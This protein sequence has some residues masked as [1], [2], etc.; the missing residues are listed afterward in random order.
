M[1]CADTNTTL[2][3]KYCKRKRLQLYV[4][5]RGYSWNTALIVLVLYRWCVYLQLRIYGRRKLLIRQYHSRCILQQLK[6]IYKYSSL[7]ILNKTCFHE[8]SHHEWTNRAR[9]YVFINYPQQN[10]SLKL[11]YSTVYGS[12]RGLQKSLVQLFQHVHHRRDIR[13][14]VPKQLKQC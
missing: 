5:D 9:H 7:A 1:L 10:R 6:F 4:H 11:L 3:S 13:N 12:W 8:W 14:R 2:E